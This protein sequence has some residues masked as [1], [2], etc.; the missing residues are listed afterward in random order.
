MHTRLPAP[1]T[2]EPSEVRAVDYWFWESERVWHLAHRHKFFADVRQSDPPLIPARRSGLAVDLRLCLP[3]KKQSSH[4]IG[5][6]PIQRQVNEVTYQL[7]LPSMYRI[8]PT[9]HVSLLKPFSP[10][11]TGRTE[12]DAPPTPEFLEEAAVYQVRDILDSRRCN[13]RLEYLVN[14]EGYGPEKRSWVARD[15]ILD[16]LHLE[17][18]HRNR[19]N[20]PAP[21]G[22][23]HHRVRASGAAPGGGGNVRES[24]SLQSPQSLQSSAPTFTRSQSPEFWFPAPVPCNQNTIQKHAP[25]SHSL[26]VLPF[27]FLNQ[28][29]PH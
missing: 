28:A 29:W 17:E 6:F 20:C 24:K 21:R 15:D 18:F 1:C 9:F 13:T 14:W 26:S 25:S 8:H 7:Q 2:E 19:P 12:P 11:P 5:P 3:C 23:S 22:R 4:F 16:P 27:T 10:S